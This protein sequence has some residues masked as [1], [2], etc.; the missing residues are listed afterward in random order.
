[1]KIGKKKRISSLV[2]VL[3]LA[4]CLHTQDKVKEVDTYVSY[5]STEKKD[6]P[7]IIMSH[8]ARGLHRNYFDWAAYFREA[9]FATIIVDHHTS[10]GYIHGT[11]PPTDSGYEIRLADVSAVFNKLA[12]IPNIDRSRIWLAGWSAGAGFVFDGIGHKGVLGAFL[13]YPYSYACRLNIIDSHD[14]PV[15]VLIGEHDAGLPNCWG[16]YVDDPQYDFSIY[17]DAYHCFDCKNIKTMVTANYR[18]YVLRMIYN[19]KALNQSKIDVT[20][21]LH[22]ETPGLN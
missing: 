7:V 4:G 20:E 5:P 15:K 10:R 8:G 11:K 2:G 22:R 12:T 3:L 19:E 14:K 16:K 18:R 9:G 6:F 17:D 21:F 13:F 1:M